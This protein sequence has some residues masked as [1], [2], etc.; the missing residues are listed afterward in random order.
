MTEKAK[1]GWWP[2]GP[3]KAGYLHNPAMRLEGQRGNKG[4]RR[5][6]EEIIID[7]SRF[8]LWRRA[9]D[10]MLTGRHT[11]P[12]ILEI[13]TRAWGLRTPEGK[14]YTRSKIYKV[15]TDPFYYGVFEYPKNSGNWYQGKHKAL[16]TKAEFDRIPGSAR[17]SIRACKRHITRIRF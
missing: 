10:L 12:K 8:P 15:F 6:E 13:A 5:V 7:P 16:I 14:T 2:H 1:R 11:P 4:K 17:N 3:I 9:F